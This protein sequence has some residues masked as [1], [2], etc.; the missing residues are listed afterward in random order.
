MRL[1]PVLRFEKYSSF[2]HQKFIRCNMQFFVGVDIDR[3]LE[4]FKFKTQS[5]YLYYITKSNL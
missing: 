1:L 2:L 5:H 3:A 4:N